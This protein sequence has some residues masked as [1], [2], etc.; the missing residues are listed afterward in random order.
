ML[1]QNLSRRF[2]VKRLILAERLA[3]ECVGS[4]SNG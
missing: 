4:A 3:T 2:M 1:V